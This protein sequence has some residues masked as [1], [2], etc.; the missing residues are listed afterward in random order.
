MSARP[1]V[2]QRVL[3]PARAATREK[4]IAT[5]IELATEGGYE[6]VGIRQIA[7]AAGV[8]VP[9]AYQHASSKDQLLM[10]ALMS[11]GENSTDAVRARPPRGDTP[12]ERL[13]SV[14]SRILREAGA[15]PLLYQALY[16]G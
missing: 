1:R 6:A 11:L 14:F 16:R 5:V 13:N 2:I 9:T 15:K 4:L 12:A 7:A 3:S 8:S 10:E